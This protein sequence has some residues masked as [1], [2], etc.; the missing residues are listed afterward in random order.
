M[1]FPKPR[2]RR[3]SQSMAAPHSGDMFLKKAHNSDGSP[4]GPGGR[5]WGRHPQTTYT[6]SQYC[7]VA[8]LMQ[9]LPALSPLFLTCTSSMTA[10]H[11]VL[12]GHIAVPKLLIFRTFLSTSIISTLGYFESY[13][14]DLNYEL[15]L[16]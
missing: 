8:S 12:F 6:C 9:V 14:N 2:R 1:I 4:H 15:F 3:N 11:T 5:V 10:R 16:K 13:N 7:V